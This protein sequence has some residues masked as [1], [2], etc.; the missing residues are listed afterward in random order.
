M[1]VL[2]E[3]LQKLAPILTQLD[4]QDRRERYE[5]GDFPR[6]HT[7]KDLWKR[8]RW[9]LYWKACDLGGTLDSDM[10]NDAHIDT[11]LRSL[12]RDFN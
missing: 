1:K 12:V 9:D 5:H 7:T 6:A 4:T 2:K 3:D 8:Y 11:A 10:Y